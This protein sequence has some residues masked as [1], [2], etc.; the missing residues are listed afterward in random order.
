MATTLTMIFIV[1]PVVFVGSLAGLFLG[2]LIGERLMPGSGNFVSAA[3][4]IGRRERPKLK[5][6]RSSPNARTQRIARKPIPAGRRDVRDWR[7]G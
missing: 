7:R 1:V 2:S 6:D 3:R 4:S 5:L